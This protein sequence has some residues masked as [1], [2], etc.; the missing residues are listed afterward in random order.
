MGSIPT[1]S[2]PEIMSSNDERT[3]DAYSEEIDP[4]IA[5]LFG[6]DDDEDSGRPDI[7]DL[8]GDG[9]SDKATEND[10]SDQNA[11]DTT[12]ES[13]P[14]I[15]ALEGTS[16]PFFQDKEFYK[17]ALGGEDAPAKR[18]H[19]ILGQFLATEDPQEKS[20]FRGQLIPAF[21]NVAESIAKKSH[22]NLPDPKRI[23]LRFGAVL[24]N[25][26]SKEH[27][28]TLQKI[29]FNNTTGEPVHY[30]DEWLSQIAQ[31]QIG[32]SATDE[33]KTKKQDIPGSKLTSQ[34]ERA[35]GNRDSSFSA[36]SSKLAEL[37]S[38][39]GQ[40]RQAV[41]HLQRREANPAYPGLKYGYASDQRSQLSELANIARQL[42]PADREIERLYSQLGSANDEFESLRGQAQDEG[43]VE[44]VVDAS[45]IEEEFNTVRQMA[46]LCV[47]RQ[48]N[49]LPVLMKQ[50]FR[51]N[52]R[53]IGTRENIIKHM[54]AVEAVD[55]GVFL[56]TFKRQTNRIVPHV[57]LVPC[58]GDSGICWEPFERFNRA[59]SRGRIAIP[60]FPKD[61][62]YAVVAALADLRWQVAKEKAQHYWM[63]EG[64]TGQY[65]QWFESQKQRGDVRAAF[66]QDYILW[67]TKESEGTQKLEKDVRPVFW[68][69]VPFRQELKDSLKNRGFVYSELYKRDLNRAASDGY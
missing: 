10:G 30:V 49:H 29:I 32:T 63:E 57:V 48:G 45:A 43:V 53:D 17:K 64:L 4:E 60:L 19:K 20:L 34:V 61:V 3:N 31:G 13:F 8:F 18:F 54:A 1:T 68:R 35:R 15:T 5:E 51:P 50:Y 6:V 38:L 66:I 28:M 42:G 46:K 69:H 16:R 39:E 37:D 12:R 40:L 62:R 2:K 7:D 55:P 22:T 26:L 58:Y 67:I 27:A 59:T 47:G 33:V 9:S 23:L 41:E 14:V 24:P 36:L 44:T 52:I 56:R 25:L 21:W 11:Q 65:Y